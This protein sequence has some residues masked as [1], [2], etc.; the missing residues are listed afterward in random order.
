MENVNVTL[1]TK[2]VSQLTGASVRQLGYWGRSGLIKHGEKRGS[3]VRQRRAYTFQEVIAAM[4]IVQL[5]RCGCPL[6]QVRLAVNYLR[7]HFPDCA[8]AKVLTGL[9]L[10]TDGKRVYVLTDNREILDV[11]TRQHVW[12]VA[13]GRL[14]REA[15]EQIAMLPVVWT[16]VIE[17]DRQKYHLLAEQDAEAGGYIV[18]CKELHGALEQGET[19]K[20]AM[21]NGRAAVESVLAFHQRKHKSGSV[22]VKAG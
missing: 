5:R 9:T 1:G 7:S 15:K 22:H 4:T 6:Q 8:D 17:I 20:E 12:S 18:Q 3:G 10:L 14:V 19:L 2:K 11:V 16:E 13:L 21:A